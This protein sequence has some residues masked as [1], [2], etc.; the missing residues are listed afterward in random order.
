M[1]IS[2]LELHCAHNGSSKKWRIGSSAD[3]SDY[4][5]MLRPMD[6]QTAIASDTRA[7]AWLEQ[8]HLG[9]RSRAQKLLEAFAFI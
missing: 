7:R 4:R 2:P 8:F 6:K 1:N 9:D 3:L 5:I